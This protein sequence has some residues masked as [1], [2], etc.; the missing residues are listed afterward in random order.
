MSASSEVLRELASH[1]H[2][3]DED[4]A[5]PLNTDIL[6]RS[7]LY[8]STPEF[9]NQIW[10]ETQSL[11]LQIASLLPKLQQDPSPLTRFII[12]LAKP[13][14]FED[15]KDV[16]FEIGLDLQA[17]PFHGLLLTLLGKATANGVDAQALANRPTVMLSIVRLWLCTQDAGIASQA[18]YLLTSLLQVSKNEPALASG[19]NSLRTYG[20]GPM[21]RRL[22]GDRDIA[23]LYYHYTSLKELTSSPAPVLS[24]REKTVAQARLLHGCHKWGLSIGTLWSRLIVSTWSARLA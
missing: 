17:V 18:E 9:R 10:K 22:F 5:T 11:F 23:S 13:Y 4:P 20:T 8:T 2:K 16:E 21:W 12:K 19:Q 6:E 1:L 14:R 3:V 15:I 24:K 7:E